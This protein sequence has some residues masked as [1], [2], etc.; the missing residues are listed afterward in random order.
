MRYAAVVVIAAV[1][2]AAPTFG[3]DKPPLSY[4][5]ATLLGFETVSTGSSST[6]THHSFSLGGKTF[7]QPDTV[8]TDD[9]HV[10]VYRLKIGDVV[11]SVRGNKSLK[12]H[13]VGDTVSVSVNEKEKALYILGKNGKPDGC[14]IMGEAKVSESEKTN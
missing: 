6:I 13:A 7:D 8:S 11:Y 12:D 9:D 5:S 2:A 3:K 10:R 1:L 4:V 14:R